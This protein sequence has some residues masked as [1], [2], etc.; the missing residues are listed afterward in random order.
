MGPG[1]TR[2]DTQDSTGRVLSFSSLKVL[3]GGGGSD[4]FNISGTQAAT[5]NGGTGDDT[6]AFVANGSSLTGSIH[7]GT[8]SVRDTLTYSGLTGPV[9]LDLTSTLLVGIELAIGSNGSDTLIGAPSGSAFSITGSN[10]GTVG[11]LD[12]QNV[13]NLTGGTGPDSFTFANDSASLSGT[14]DGKKGSDTLS[15]ADMTVAQTIVLTGTGTGTGANDGFDGTATSLSAAGF[16]SI[17]LLVSS[18]SVTDSVKGL[19]SS[20][21]WTS[22]GASVNYDS[23]SR[24]M[25]LLGIETLKGGSGADT[26][27]LSGSAIRRVEAG[28][29]GNTINAS[30]VTT[31][32]TLIGGTGTDI[33]F[34]GQGND[35]LDGGGGSLDEVRQT[36]DANQTLTNSLLT[37]MGTDSL[38]GFE[39]AMLTVGGFTGRTIDARGF[40]TPTTSAT[41]API[42]TLIGGT[43]DDKIY[44]SKGQDSII[45]N[46]GNDSLDGFQSADKL[47]GNDGNDKLRGGYDSDTL[48]GNDTLDGGDGDDTIAGGF[49]NDSLLGG[50]ASVIGSFGGNDFL[51]GGVG[52]DTLIGLNGADTL[53]DD[54]GADNLQ[55]GNGLD[56][57]IGGANGFV[58]G[59]PK[60][61]TLSLW[62]GGNRYAGRWGRHRR[63]RHS[64]RYGQRV[65]IN[66]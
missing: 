59:V 15:F 48:D 46:A 63:R 58:N 50:L 12:F 5:L 60:G 61:D 33:L 20:A 49:G 28:D 7:G 53:L 26:F 30:A 34:G 32:I 25:N 27:T 36:V 18:Q 11:S 1:T 8:H 38:S 65:G 22:S 3:N 17:N 16:K 9:S 55:G 4:L 52:N 44:G 39:K 62:P 41:F 24:T 14:I 47:F 51:S 54:D 37:G 21:T 64:R 29:G 2:S 66:R 42:T 13:E 6:F 45:G 56:L 43:G 10:N 23:S 31:N 40:G 57:L 35:V 19:D